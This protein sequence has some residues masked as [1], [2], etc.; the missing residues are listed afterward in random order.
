MLPFMIVPIIFG[1]RNETFKVALGVLGAISVAIMFMTVSSTYLFPYTDQNPLANE[2][3]PYFF[4]SQIGQNW[5]FIWGQYFGLTIT[6]FLS[7]LP[8]LA[9]AGVLAGRIV[10]L[11]RQGRRRARPKPVPGLEVS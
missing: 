5:A 3:I 1:I 7:L 9:V 10:W 4:H 8:F 11:L 6:G 2:V